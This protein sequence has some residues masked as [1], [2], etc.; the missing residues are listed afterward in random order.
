MEAFLDAVLSVKDHFGAQP[1][2]APTA[3]APERPGTAS[4]P[5]TPYD[6]LW[7]SP[8]DRPQAPA[9]R[10]FPAHPERDILGFIMT[11][12]RDLEDWQRDIVGIVRQEMLYFLPQMQT[13]ILNEGW[14]V[15]WHQ[16]IMNELDLSPAE[17]A[18]FG[19]LHASVVSPGGRMRINPYYV[20]FK[21]LLDIERRWNE[22]SAEERDRFGRQ[23]G[24]GRAKLFEV[25]ES[26]NDQTLI[27]KYLT[28][29]LVAELDLYTYELVDDEWRVAETDWRAVRDTLVRSMDNFGLPYIAVVDADFA[30]NRELYLKHSYDGVELDIRYAERT[31]QYLHQ[32]WGRTV[33]VETVIDDR[34]VRLTYDGRRNSK[35]VL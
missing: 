24:T 10:P 4:R 27:R 20:G 19:G 9:P 30:G 2:L 26:E 31:M 15:L 5:A 6:D 13:K 23:A 25:R 34:A 17:H 33:H 21:I 29:D 32:L 7:L 8:P 22:P 16:R 11:H 12:A 35:T 14:A 3:P 18:R 1:G 28:A